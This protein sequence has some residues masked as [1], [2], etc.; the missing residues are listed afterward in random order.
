MDTE[1]GFLFKGEGKDS[2]V[3][4]SS[5]VRFARNVKDYP[6]SE[7]LDP[8]S[9][10]ELEQKIVSLFPQK[11]YSIIPLEK[12]REQ[13]ALP[14][15]ESLLISPDFAAKKGPHTLVLQKEKNLSVMV[16]E[17]DHIRLQCMMNG[18]ALDE[19]FANACAEEERLDAALT[20]SFDEKLGYLTHCPTNLGTGMRASV[21]LFLPALS[22]AGKIDAIASYLPKIG[23]TLRGLYGENSA[24]EAYMFQLSNRITLG[25]T[26][27]EILKRVRSAASRVISEER[28]ERRRMIE[29][30]KRRFADRVWRAYGLLTSARMLDSKEFFSLY[31]DVRLGVVCGVIGVTDC[32]KLDPLLAKAM[33][34]ALIAAYGEKAENS[35]AR[36]YLR[37]ETVRKALG[38]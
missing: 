26:E 28:A 2:D 35:D 21:M 24:P 1:L 12:K 17:E 20:F 31:A 36:D 27:E 33:P 7:R 14:Y 3:V 4:F 19:A 37:A 29:S 25:V 11:E 23:L 10:K 6:F 32:K 22:A 15:V 8:P 9:A 38:E 30:D 13:E 34:A 5:R 16:L 18:F